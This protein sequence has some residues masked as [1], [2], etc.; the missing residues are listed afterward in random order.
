MEVIFIMYA[1]ELVELIG[2]EDGNIRKKN[3]WDLNKE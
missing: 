2:T 1:M 3:Y